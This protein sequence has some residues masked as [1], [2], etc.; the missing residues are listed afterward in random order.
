MR[1]KFSSLTKKSLAIAAASLSMLTSKAA[2]APDL[3]KPALREDDI[4]RGMNRNKMLRRKLILKLNPA[5]PSRSLLAT[6]SSHASHSSHSSHA[7]HSSHSSG[8]Y[9]G[10]YNNSSGGDGSGLGGLLVGGAVVY[11]IYRLAGKRKK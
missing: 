3:N 8:G 11:G 6:H 1:S 2:I 9:S 7:S 10:G 5:D 4:N